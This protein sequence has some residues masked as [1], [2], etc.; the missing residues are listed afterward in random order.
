MVCI[1]QIDQFDQTVGM[2]WLGKAR[3][4]VDLGMRSKVNSRMV[5]GYVHQTRS[6]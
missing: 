6:C 2:V 1:P 5:V 4:A 3:L